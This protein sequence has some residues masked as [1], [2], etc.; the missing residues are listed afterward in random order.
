MT[1]PTARFAAE[2]LLGRSDATY[3]APKEENFGV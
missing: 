3:T 2:L 1:T